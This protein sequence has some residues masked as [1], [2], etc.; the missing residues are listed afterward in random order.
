METD[1]HSQALEAVQ[2]FIMRREKRMQRRSTAVGKLASELTPTGVKWTLTQLHILSMVQKQPEAL[3]NT[4]LAERLHLSKPAV[5][6]AVRPLVEQQLLLPSRHAANQKEVYYRLSEQGDALA[7]AHDRIHERMK[8]E[9]I[10]LFKAF[11]N[12]ELD[13]IIRFL[14]AWS[15]LI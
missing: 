14:T 10:K 8:E 15:N 9:Y 12:E 1:K 7:E 6:K 2:Q 5:T 11:S 4:L 3:N 13:V